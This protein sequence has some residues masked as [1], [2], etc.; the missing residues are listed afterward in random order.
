MKEGS[1]EDAS[2]RKSRDEVVFF[3]RELA[4]VCLEVE[5]HLLESVL[6]SHFSSFKHFRPP[7]YSSSHS[8]GCKVSALHLSGRLPPPHPLDFPLHSY[9]HDSISVHTEVC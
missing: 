4:L 6:I 5:N 8:E 7:C 3:C 2:L 1:I 9:V